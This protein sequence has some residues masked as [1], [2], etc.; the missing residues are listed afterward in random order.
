MRPPIKRQPNPREEA[1]ALKAEAEVLGF[2]DELI[3]GDANRLARQGLD[4]ATGK[5]K[6]INEDLL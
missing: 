4:P 1:D 6:K 2:I 5:A 3:K